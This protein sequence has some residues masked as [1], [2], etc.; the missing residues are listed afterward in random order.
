MRNGLSLV[1]NRW[2]P[3]VSSRRVWV[4]W[5]RLEPTFNPLCCSMYAQED[6]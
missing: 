4:G 3:G 2:R 1:A 6:L 5:K